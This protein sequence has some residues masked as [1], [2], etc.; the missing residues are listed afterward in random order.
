MCY[1]AQESL[2]EKSDMEK[3][4]EIIAEKDAQVVTKERLK[5]VNLGSDQQ[6]PRP[7]SINSKLSKEE[8][9]ELILSLKEFKDVF[10]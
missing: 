5:E 9:V 10:A 1:V 4:E 2:E 3:K 7:I 6:E 8:K